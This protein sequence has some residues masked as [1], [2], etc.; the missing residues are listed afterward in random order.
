MGGEGYMTENELERLWRDSRINTIVEG[1]NEVMHAFVF[2]YGSKQLGEHMLAV[3][4]RPWKMPGH[5]LKLAGELFL[6]IRPRAPRISLLDGSLREHAQT[7]AE[8][9]REF[10]HQVKRMFKVHEES[11]ISKQ[12][13]QYRLSSMSIWIHAMTCSLSRLDQSIR[14]GLNGEDLKRDRDIVNHVCNIARHAFYEAVRHLDDNTDDT[15]RI[16]ADAAWTLREFLPHSDYSIPERTPNEAARGQGRVPDQTHI[17]QFGS[18]SLAKETWDA[19]E[20]RI[21]EPMAS[22]EKDLS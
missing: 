15:M 1:A 7:L 13:I 6:G 2:A 16:A 21:A 12:M 4:A 18:G 5:A 3:R 22:K 8:L 20:P 9:T 19:A 17:Q 10:S 11:L 14:T